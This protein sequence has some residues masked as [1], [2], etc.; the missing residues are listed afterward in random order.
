VDLLKQ[1]AFKGFPSVK[2]M[3]K[4]EANTSKLLNDAGKVAYAEALG[5]FSV[6][7]LIPYGNKDS[8]YGNE[9]RAVNI[10]S[11]VPH[12]KAF[13]ALDQT[14]KRMAGYPYSPLSAGDEKAVY[15]IREVPD[16]RNPYV[17]HLDVNDDDYV[18]YTF[19]LKSKTASA[20]PDG[21][22]PLPGEVEKRYG[23]G[24]PLSAK[25]KWPQNPALRVRGL[26]KGTSLIPPNK[27]KE[28]L[29][30]RLRAAAAK[31]RYR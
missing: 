7:V 8:F 28:I 29:T 21:F 3:N 23:H 31:T 27:V 13:S 22:S 12:V 15:Q 16:A 20:T 1:I 11:L 19:L 10:L 9:T 30:S 17:R 4:V 26:I 5:R 18:D 25:P 14:G 6:P 2:W 24:K